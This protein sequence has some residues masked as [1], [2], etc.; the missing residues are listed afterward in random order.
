MN[1]VNSQQQQERQ[2][3]EISRQADP[4]ARN[5]IVASPGVRIGVED[6][7]V[8]GQFGRMPARHVYTQAISAILVAFNPE[9]TS[10]AAIVK[11]VARFCKNNGLGAIVR[12]LDTTRTY[13]PNP[14]QTLV[15]PAVQIQCAGFEAR[16]KS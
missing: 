14:G 8:Y 9:T 16:W 15:Q 10:K 6:I 7:S 5:D 3:R 4:A 12:T 1:S 13:K 2:E 11:D